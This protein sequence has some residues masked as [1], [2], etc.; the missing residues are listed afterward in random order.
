MFFSVRCTG[1][2]SNIISRTP[3]S[4]LHLLL[5]V[6]LDD[7]AAPARRVR[8]G[9][10]RYM[11]AGFGELSGG[12]DGADIVVP[13]SGI[14]GDQGQVFALSLG[15]QHAVEGVGMVKRQIANR[16]RVLKSDRQRAESLALE[17]AGH[18]LSER[19]PKFQTAQ[20]G[21]D[22]DFPNGGGAHPN[23]GSR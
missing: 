1:H 20:C 15:N 16:K 10:S 9:R 14:G 7:G 17:F 5:S 2:K 4:A 11:A 13:D 8:C 21:L 12:I 22:A 3:T 18:D 19:F 6:V 23:G